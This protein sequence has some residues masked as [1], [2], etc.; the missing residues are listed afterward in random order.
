ME[1]SKAPGCGANLRQKWRDLRGGKP[2]K[3]SN[4]DEGPSMKNESTSPVGHDSSKAPA[5]DKSES[6]GPAKAVEDNGLLSPTETIPQESPPEDDHALDRSDQKVTSPEWLTTIHNALWNKAYSNLKQDPKKA[7]YVEAYERLVLAVFLD[8]PISDEAGEG[9][10]KKPDD[11]R[12]NLGEE[13]MKAIVAKGLARV[14]GS[15]KVMEKINDV[16]GVFTE[17]KAFLDIPLKNIPQTALPWAVI[18]STVDIQVKPAK[19]AADLYHG[20]A[21]VVSRMSWYSKAVDKLL[22]DENIK[23]NKS[24]AEMNHDLEKA[25]VDL[26]QSMLFYQVTSVCSYY[27]SQLL[28]LLRGF[29]NLDDWSGDLA[30]VKDAENALQKNI[31]FYNQEHIKD[32][33]RHITMTSEH[34]KEL[35]EYRDCLLALRWIDPRAEIGDIQAR[36]ENIIKDLY[37]WILLTEEYR[38][39]SKWGHPTPVRLW[40]SGQAGTGKT[41]LLIGII[42][43]LIARGLP[44][45]ERP[46]V[47]Y[48]LCQ[49]TNNQANNGVA[50]LRSLIWLLLLEQ[51]HLFSHIQKEY[52]HSKNRLFTDKNAFT[53]LR[54]ILRKMLEDKSLKRAIIIIDALDEC[55]EESR[56]LLAS[57]ID[58]VSSAQKFLEIKWL[59]SSRPLPEIPASVQDV[60]L[61]THSLLKLD[62]HDMSHSIHRYIDMKMVQLRD[63]A[64]KKNRVEE[65]ADKLK[66]QASNTYIWV[67]LVCRELLH[68]HEFMWTEVVNK[69]PKKLEGLYGYLLDRLANLDSE[70]M[71]TCCKNVLTAAMLARDPLALSE[72]EILAGLPEGEDAAEA[73]VQECRSFLTIRNSTVYLIHQSAQ[74]YLQKHYQKLYDV[75]LATLHHQMYERALSGLKQILRENIYRLSHYGVASAEV[76]IPNPDP[77]VSVRYACRYWVYNL[78]Q[79]GSTPTDMEDI[80]FFLNKH[81]LHWLEAMSLLGSFPDIVRLVCQLISISEV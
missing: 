73:I 57:F 32:Q 15:K 11:P 49:A 52:L 34:Q 76:Q 19:A 3:Q 40:V 10:R 25:I 67:S 41:M 35:D 43:E 48:F 65:I 56:E 37:N 28:V 9:D 13:R 77:L 31:T 29:L 74:D 46:Q 38:Q 54:D 1:P 23:G 80:L 36:N 75:S 50:V 70:I 64:R 59:V 20:V 27:K 71:S 63:K 33:I 5:K 7:K 47:L 60:T 42:K 24:L 78:E 39:F 55:E 66:T 18:S 53:T 2:K 6:A 45:T 14:E 12:S 16:S 69:I 51:P 17:V 8:T 4:R 22:S 44:D 62:G 30:T 26:Y 21:Y 68:T 81:F 61:P 72:I 58:E 79:S